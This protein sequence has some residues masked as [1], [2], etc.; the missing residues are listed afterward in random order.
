MSDEGV[1]MD[2]NKKD[3]NAFCPD[4]GHDLAFTEDGCYCKGSYQKG[5]NC[6]WVCKGCKPRTAVSK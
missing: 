2:N 1:Y 5:S 6:K 4:C 3:C